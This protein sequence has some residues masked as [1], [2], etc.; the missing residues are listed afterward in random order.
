MDI[1]FLKKKN[2]NNLKL[3]LVTFEQA[4]ALK[5]L[6]FPQRAVSSIGWYSTNGQ[7]NNSSINAPLDL[8]EG[9]CYASTLE[10]VVKWLR[11]EKEI[12]ID[13]LHQYLNNDYS[14]WFG[15]DKNDE[16]TTGFNTYEEALSEGIDKAIE[17]LKKQQNICNYGR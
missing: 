6:G 1:N 12:Y 13:V 10:F 9:E 16:E 2:M 3:P 4:K 7:L 15:Y 11:E 17:I 14:L 5:E 8:L